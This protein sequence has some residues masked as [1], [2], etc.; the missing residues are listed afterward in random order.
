MLAVSYM[1]GKA[2]VLPDAMLVPAIYRIHAEAAQFESIQCGKLNQ[3]L[4]SAERTIVL[5]IN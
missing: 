4:Y 5:L 1:N 3:S 2:D